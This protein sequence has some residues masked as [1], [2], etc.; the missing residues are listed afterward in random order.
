M[1]AWRLEQASVIDAPRAPATAQ[2][3]GK[4]LSSVEGEGGEREGGEGAGGE[5]AA[6]EAAH[7]TL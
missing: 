4:A 2:G 3:A 7:V 1:L 6:W 5:G